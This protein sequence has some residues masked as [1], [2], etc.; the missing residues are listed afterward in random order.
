[1]EKI[2]QSKRLFLRRFNEEE[3][4]YFYQLNAD[5]EVMRYTGDKAF[6]D[7]KNAKEFILNYSHYDIHGFGRWSVYTLEEN[8]WIGW[9]GLKRNEDGIVDLG[10]RFL[11]DEWNKGYATEIAAEV[12]KFGFEILK[13][14]KI[15]GR[16]SVENQASIAVL[17]KIGMKYW[18]T[19][20][21]EQLGL[22]HCYTYTKTKT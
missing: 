7:V 4:P 2:I 13:L 3:A 11:K 16:C 9:C 14:H 21:I 15:I 19:E 10:F 1:M 8:K 12:I 6:I 18:K 17:R 22:C 5:Q 20:N